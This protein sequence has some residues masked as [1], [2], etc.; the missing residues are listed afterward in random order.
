VAARVRV[1]GVD[2]RG[3]RPYDAGEQFGAAAIQVAIAAVNAENAGHTGEQVRFHGA[4]FAAA[5]MVYRDQVAETA[6]AFA[7]RYH[8]QL[9][10]RG[11]TPRFAERDQL[12]ENHRPTGIAGAD[13]GQH[14]SEL[15]QGQWEFALGEEQRFAAGFAVR[16]RQIRRRQQQRRD[17]LH[18]YRRAEPVNG[19]SRELF[20]GD[21]Q[22]KI[23]CQ[24]IEQTDFFVGG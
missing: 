22:R 1:F 2:R 11:E 21:R 12:I 16:R 5:A 23:L 6:R 18:R 17:S 4:E 15:R 10:D 19:N 3:Q 14:V 13:H 8:D 24:P 7:Q 20:V 9:L